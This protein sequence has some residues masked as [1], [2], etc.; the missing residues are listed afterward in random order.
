MP[1]QTN[2]H[3]LSKCFHIL[4]DFIWTLAQF[5]TAIF[6]RSWL[7]W[8]VW[9]VVL[10][11]TKISI[12]IFM[13]SKK[14]THHSASFFQASISNILLWGRSLTTGKNRENR[15]THLT[16]NVVASPNNSSRV[17]ARKSVGL[18]LGIKRI[19]AY[20]AF[21]TV[22]LMLNLQISRIFLNVFASCSS[23]AWS[24]ER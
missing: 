19:S 11:F 14:T 15:A 10:S 20:S 6:Y 22:Y 12:F 8:K 2:R 21:S 5:D 3:G 4:S 9:D 24:A 7:V 18:I 13:N 1:F 16:R 17:F 23:E